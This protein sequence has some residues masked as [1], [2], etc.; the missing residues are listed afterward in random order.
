[1]LALGLGIS[2]LLN[3]CT[4]LFINIQVDTVLFDL[5]PP[6]NKILIMHTL[7]VKSIDTSKDDLKGAGNHTKINS[8]PEHRIPP[9]SV[10]FLG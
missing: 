10:L 9:S 7:D 8:R 1:M 3:Y 4:S 6:K 5:R 2:I